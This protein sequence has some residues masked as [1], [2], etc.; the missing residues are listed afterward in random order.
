[1]PATVE[2]AVVGGGGVGVEGLVLFCRIEMLLLGCR[3]E[4]SLL[5]RR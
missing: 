5:S 1:V 4:E 2:D 3:E